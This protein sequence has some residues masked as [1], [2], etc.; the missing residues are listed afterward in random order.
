MEHQTEKPWYFDK[1]RRTLLDMHIEEWDD[2]FLR[3]FSPQDYLDALEKGQVNAPMIYVQSHV[4][5]CYWPTQYGRM[6]KAFAS[7][8]HA[9]KELFEACHAK[10]MAVVTYYSCIFD[11]WAYDAHPAWR[12]IDANGNPSR[13]NGSRYGLCC[14]N[15]QEYRAFTKA[16]LKEISAEFE[17]EG[18]FCDMTFWP[19]VCHCDACKER[20][21]REVGGEMPA[22]V[23]FNDANFRLFQQK[24]TD[25]LGEFA[26]F[27]TV[28]VKTD[29]PGCTVEHQ[30][31]NSLGF[32]RF[33]NNENVA[34]ASD[35]IGSDLYGGIE[36]QSF[37]CK[38]WYHLTPNKPF[39]YMTSRCYPS[40][41]EHTMTKSPA[42]LQKCVMMTY[43]HHGASLLIDAV[44]PRGTIDHRV[45]DLMGEVFGEAKRYEDYTMHG[46]MTY[47]IAL[48]FSLDN[49]YDY[50][51]PP[52][53]SAEAADWN[54]PAYNA[55]F[56]A[57]K[58]LREQHMPF[59][60]VNSRKPQQIQGAKVLCC[61][62]VR[63]LRPD[64]VEAIR[65][66]VAD[67]GSL[68]MSGHCNSALL[69]TFFGA[70][71]GA[72][73]E[74]TL[75]FVSPAPAGAA[76][77]AEFTPEYPMTVAQ[78][79]YPLAQPGTGEVL[80]TLTLPYTVPGAPMMFPNDYPWAPYAA[81]DARNRFSSIH[82]NPPGIFTD[83]P[84]MLKTAYHKGVVVWS[85]VSFEAHDRYQNKRIFARLMR[86]LLR[87]Q[88]PAF[89]AQAP[90]R[91]EI[92][93]FD[94]P[95]RREMTLGLI[96]VDNAFEPDPT[97]G[98]QISAT[99]PARPI[100]VKWA[101]TAEP[102]AYTYDGGQIHVTVDTVASYRMMVVQF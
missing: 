49:K 21:Q 56:G 53:H 79:A 42:Q 94:S 58:A 6:H 7:R 5:L 61:C 17:Y 51:A 99:C 34:D 63:D 20:W 12:M 35:Y 92:I 78:K 83:Q 75:T 47:D 46:T 59:G 26:Q 2:T 29:K 23:D 84:A 48:Y 27:V 55:I 70:Q 97:C 98:I 93:R 13:A 1:R 77:L 89:A 16:R 69:A 80:A 102:I 87:G 68:Y 24:R 90:A 57:S 15:N 91:L 38:V 62:D 96:N 71:S 25:W 9:M 64:E 60:I 81:D 37:A 19:M 88:T 14:P 73:T 52:K 28:C 66:F 95:E 74:E 31:G 86:E 32:W 39:Q 76:L 72:P 18:L 50:D 10:G 3:D 33:A 8:P 22:I 45:Y 100:C 85:A 41:S 43:L 65:T 101:D 54:M 30:Y 82:S 44:D 40:L 36:E 67:G 11:N 4:G